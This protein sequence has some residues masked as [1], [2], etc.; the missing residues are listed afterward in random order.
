VPVKLPLA[1]PAVS[2]AI[3]FDQAPPASKRR[4][5]AACKSTSMA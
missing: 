4:F 3:I 5:G 1:V 2:F